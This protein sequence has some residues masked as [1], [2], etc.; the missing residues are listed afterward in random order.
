M[1]TRKSKEISRRT[2]KKR[3]LF[4]SGKR[5]E[6]KVLIIAIGIIS[7]LLVL[8]AVGVATS[9]KIKT[10][11]YIIEYANL[12]KKFDGYKIAQLT[13]YHKGAYGNGNETLISAVEAAGPDIIVFTG[14]LIDKNSKD[15]KK[16]N[17]AV[18]EPYRHS[19]RHMD[20]GQSLL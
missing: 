1:E 2:Q 3:R 8:F 6:Q 9:L 10:R 15:I 12:P 14:D 4:K 11:S 17:G 20:K 7:V 18:R 16:H 5:K 19:T 13:D